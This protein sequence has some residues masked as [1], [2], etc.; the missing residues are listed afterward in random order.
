[1][2]ACKMESKKSLAPKKYERLTNRSISKGGG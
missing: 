1:M 2:V